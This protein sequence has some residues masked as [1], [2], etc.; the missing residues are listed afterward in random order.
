MKDMICDIDS[1]SEAVTLIERAKQAQ[2]ILRTFPQ[3]KIDAIVLSMIS[4]AEAASE[5]LAKMAV[6]ETGFGNVKDK[7]EKNKFASTTLYQHIKNIKT[8]GVLKEDVAKNTVEIATPMGVLVALIPSTNPTSTA[9]YKTIIAIKS[10]NAIVM[11]PHP[12]AKNCIIEAANIVYQ[13]A[14]K[15]GAPEGII[16]WMTQLSQEGTHTLMRHPD[17]AM[18]LATGGEAMVKA[19]YSSG[20]P[21]IGV[22][23]GNCPALIDKSANVE[24]AIKKIFKS[25]TFDNGVICASE[26][27]IVVEKAIEAQLKR[28]IEIHDGYLLSAQESEKLGKILLR[29][30]GTMN[31]EIVG[32]TAGYIANIAGISLPADVQ[33]LV[34]QQST[35]AHSNPYSREKLAPILALYVEEDCEHAIQRCV[36]LL[37]NEGSGHTAS[38]HSQNIDVIREYA[39]RVPVS[40]C[41]INTPSALGAIGSTT[42]LAPAL[43]LGCGAIGGSSVS[44]NIGPEHLINIKRVACDQTQLMPY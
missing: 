12:T 34:S 22:G 43:T 42:K 16:G 14:I 18:I 7:E 17:T 15:A 26:Q 30:N 13:A 44:D 37:E 33:V 36:E 28:A 25:K 5:H 31:P 19:A 24:E 4:A 8:V 32:R 9:I 20:N 10:G 38:I 11:S 6:Y 27:S 2:F 29:D 23:P 35:V 1:T 41:L 3:D 39:A 21:A 40:R